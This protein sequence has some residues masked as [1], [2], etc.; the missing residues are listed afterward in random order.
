[1]GED[2][3][4]RVPQGERGRRRVAL[5]LEA[6]EQELAQSGYEQFT[7]NAVAA[8]AGISIGS[9][10]QFFPN[11]EAL[12]KAL[13][14]RYH[15]T[16]RKLYDELFSSLSKEQPLARMVDHLIDPLVGYNARNRAFQA[17]FCSILVPLRMSSAVAEVRTE[18][19]SRVHR[20]F[21]ERQPD[22]PPERRSICVLVS[23]HAVEAL[24][25]LATDENGEVN[26]DVVREIKRLL[27]AY[28]E[29]I[30]GNS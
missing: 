6:A 20:I 30:L 8:R 21:A 4:R 25:P 18:V 9:I 26:Q 13:A 7:T 24:L 10:Y 12:V 29:P 23:V 17:L 5:I 1:M 15:E 28:L 22:L 3:V 14:A 2:S 19:I 27:L 11:K 16:I